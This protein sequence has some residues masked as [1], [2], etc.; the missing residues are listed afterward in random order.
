MEKRLLWR[1][2]E[3]VFDGKSLVIEGG[4][5]R[6]FLPCLHFFNEDRRIY[7]T[8][9]RASSKEEAERLVKEGLAVVFT[10]GELWELG[11]SHLP[12]EERYKAI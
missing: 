7:L 10:L 12:E 11:T 1:N 6:R 3:L 5:K 8:N 4:G 2:Y 9:G